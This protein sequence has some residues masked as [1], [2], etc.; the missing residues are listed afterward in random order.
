MSKLK[1]TL[2]N[3][4]VSFP[5][6]LVAFV[7]YVLGFSLPSTSLLIAAMLCLMG[8]FNLAMWFDL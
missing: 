1:K 5:V 4:P 3:R 8:A 7:L 6:G 2:N